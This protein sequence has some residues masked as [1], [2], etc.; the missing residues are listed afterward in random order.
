M[1]E[2]MKKAAASLL[3]EKPI[4][5]SYRIAMIEHEGVE[6]MLDDIDE[7]TSVLLYTEETVSM[8]G[9]SGPLIDLLKEV[10]EGE[11]RFHSVGLDGFRASEEVVKDIDDRPTWMLKRPHE[12][13]KEPEHQ[14]V[15]LQEDDAEVINSFWNLSGGDSTEYI[16]DRIKNG[17]AYGIRR[18]GEL[19]A[20]CLTHHLTESAMTMGFL[21]VKEEWRGRGF[22]RSVTES[23]CQYALENGS[24]PVIDIFKD[25]EPSLNLAKSLGFQHIGENHWFSGEITSE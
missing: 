13:F 15:E 22:A 23:M 8:S 19:V 17:P 14:T 20:W 2:K 18:D 7:P 6:I 11:Y 12:A 1:A 25:N 5:N 16:K 9:E 21:H 4:I 10:P 3:R 24:I